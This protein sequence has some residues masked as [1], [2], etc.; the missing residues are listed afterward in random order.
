MKQHARAVSLSVVILGML[1]TALAAQV[2]LPGTQPGEIHAKFTEVARC[3]MCHAKTRSGPDAPLPSW[4]SGM[5]S[6]AMRDPVFRTALAVANQDIEGIGDFCLRCHTPAGFLEGRADP[7]DASAL[8][9]NDLHGVSCEV[10]HRLLDPLSTAATWTTKH[11]PPGYGNAMLVLDPAFTM[12]GPYAD[13]SGSMP[14]RAV[15]STFLASGQFCGSCHDVSN[16]ASADDLKKQPPH[17][18]G[19][20]ERTFSEWSLS[21]FARQGPAGSC[22]SCHYERLPGGG[23]P[24]HFGNVKRDYFLRHGA[25]GGSTWVP[26]AIM[27]LWGQTDVSREALELGKQRARKLLRSA[28]SL[29][30]A[31]P[32]E[33]LARLRITNLTGHKLPTG[34]PEGRRMWVNVRF[35]DAAGKLLKESGRYGEEEDTIFGKP[36]SAP[37][38]L[39]PEDCRLYECLPAISP[40]RAKEFGKQ[41]G[42]S[43]HFVLNDVIALD[44]RIPPKGFTNAAFAEH[45]CQPVGA[46]Y[47][48]GQHWDDVDFALPAGTTTITIRLMYQSVSWEYLKFLVETD[49]TDDWG[50]RLYEAW[51][52]TGRCPPEVIA[53]LTRD[54]GK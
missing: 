49:Q 45:Q 50:R 36:V 22:Q 2:F 26:D 8:N 19:R 35:V 28:A 32:E 12:H 24:T 13:A 20:I 10:C 42:P 54:V 48:D 23:Y 1:A 27:Q 29:E 4:Q 37:T 18:Y 11:V 9:A 33:G 51:N 21:E 34:Y 40:A 44:N 53:E 47:A 17:T 41:P 16:P 15:R 39:D 6:Q 46:E 43:F 31:F 14:H 30:L 38:L 52:K 25:V 3:A 7:P 5:M